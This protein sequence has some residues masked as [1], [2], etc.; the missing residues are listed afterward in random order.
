MEARSREGD[1]NNPYL[2]PRMEGTVGLEGRRKEGRL[3]QMLDKGRI[4]W[5]PH[6]STVSSGKFV[7]LQRWQMVGENGYT[8]TSFVELLR[9]N[10]TF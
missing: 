2:F 8:S 10:C 9:N 4:V 3:V 6:P 1:A 7:A 5:E